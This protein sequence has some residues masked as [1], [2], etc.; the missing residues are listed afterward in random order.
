MG[1]IIPIVVGLSALA[2]VDAQLGYL[3]WK[4]FKDLLTH[5]FLRGLTLFGA[6]YSASGQ[7]M[8]AAMGATYLYFV[9][10]T[11]SIAKIGDNVDGHTR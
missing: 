10:R 6:A 7:N 8:L 5:P 3:D 1:N 2:I 11:D 9:I 4:Q